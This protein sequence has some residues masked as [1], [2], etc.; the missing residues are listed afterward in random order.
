MALLD[1]ILGKFTT[2]P[3]VRRHALRAAARA[4]HV[5]GERAV[6]DTIT[7]GESR[8]E[9]APTLEPLEGSATALTAKRQPEN[10]SS[11]RPR[12]R[13]KVSSKVLLPSS[14]SAAASR[15]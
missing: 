7:V 1:W 12:S 2:P 15:H 9:L 14:T 6:A 3:N 5:A 10:S 8:L 11:V 13:G 4:I